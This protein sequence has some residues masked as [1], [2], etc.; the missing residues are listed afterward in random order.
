[1]SP[2]KQKKVQPR[3]GEYP[4]VHNIDLFEFLTDKFIADVARR[5]GKPD[6]A[7]VSGFMHELHGITDNYYRE[8]LVAADEIKPAE[9]KAAFDHIAAL[10]QELHW[11]LTNLDWSIDLSLNRKWSPYFVARNERLKAVKGKNPIELDPEDWDLEYRIRKEFI[12]QIKE[13]E[14]AAT[15][16]ASGLPDKLPKPRRGRKTNDA[17]HDLVWQLWQLYQEHTQEKLRLTY[18]AIEET[19]KGPFFELTRMFLDNVDPDNRISDNA[20]GDTIRRALGKRR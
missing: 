1:M 6:L 10:S 19:Y 17:L 13:L 8:K 11:C 18:D 15:D 9:R 20:L 7:E 12:D 14:M 2:P 5:L 4:P 3:W 16:A